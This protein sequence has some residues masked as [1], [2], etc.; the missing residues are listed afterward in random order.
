M[1]RTEDG[2]FTLER[3]ITLY[4]GDLA[5][6]LGN[7]L[8]RT[9]SMIGRYRDG[10]VPQPGLEL[11]ADR[12]LRE[13]AGRLPEE[14]RIA[15]DAFDFRTALS[16]VWALVTRTNRYVEEAAPWMLAK[17]AKGGSE[18]A[19]RKLDTALYNLAESL[20]LLSLHLSPYLPTASEKVARQL[21]LAVHD[22][23][24]YA[25]VTRWGGLAPGTL[26]ARP[27]PIF[28]KVEVPEVQ[29]V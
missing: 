6:D 5:N 8:N 15:L 11:P 22:S 18:E 14:T 4:N 10:R 29:G 2:N 20:R 23:R 21:G 1:P 25:E 13:L 19:A 26:V 28:P 3:L 12:E 16:A 17:E 24:P 27:E 7:L 9:V